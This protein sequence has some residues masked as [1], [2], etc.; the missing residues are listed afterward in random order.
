MF[1]FPGLA[2][3]CRSDG[4][5]HPP[6]CP[7]RTSRDL[8]P[9]AAPPGFSQLATSFLACPRPGILR[10][11][12]PRLA[13]SCPRSATFLPE[14]HE[15][16][17]SLA[18]LG[19]PPGA[20]TSSFSAHPTQI[21]KQLHGALGSRRAGKH[22]QIAPGGQAPDHRVIGAR[23]RDAKRNS[24]VTEAA[25]AFNRLAARRSGDEGLW[26]GCG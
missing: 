26:S 6:G 2:L 15:P 19:L 3:P 12:L 14:R 17:T 18:H 4:S 24:N 1:Q 25:V 16:N 5:F 9:R 23:K 21:V 11:P 13:R 22:T 20:L 8:S 10:A 7:I